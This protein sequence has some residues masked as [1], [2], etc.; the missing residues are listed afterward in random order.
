MSA[1]PTT[2]TVMAAASTTASV[3]E[4]GGYLHTDRLTITDPASGLSQVITG[5]AHELV[6]LAWRIVGAVDKPER[7]ED[8]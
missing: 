7:D 5:T 6:A 4:L 3:V 1:E 2:Y 8:F